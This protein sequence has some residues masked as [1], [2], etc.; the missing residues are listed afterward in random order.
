[1]T[2]RIAYV[3]YPQVISQA[4]DDMLITTLLEIP[5]AF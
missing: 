5:A 2:I 3:E 1:M 4:A